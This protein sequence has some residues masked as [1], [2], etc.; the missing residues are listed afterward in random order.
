[1]KLSVKRVFVSL[2]LC[3]VTLSML[4]QEKTLQYYNT[5]ESEILPDAQTAFKKGDYERTL[6][7]CRWHYI[8][9]GDDSAYALR[10]K[11]E[12]CLQLSKEMNNLRS[13]GNIKEAKLK[14]SALLS[15]NPD[16]S[17]AKA[18]MSL[19]EPQPIVLD[20]VSVAPPDETIE[21]VTVD[22]PK[23]R[24]TETEEKTEPET[25]QPPIE[26]PL[27]VPIVSKPEVTPVMET[28]SH[29]PHTRFV[30]KAGASVLDLKQLSQTVAPEGIIGLYG[31]T[32]KFPC[33][34]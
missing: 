33:L 2:S 19:E 22:L 27:S 20:T 30:I 7:L 18:I 21:S 16:D 5:H 3:L 11:S 10:D 28:Q 34:M 17:A 14:A 1:M 9:F 29:E 31:D 23:E 26:D 6:E 8:I 24:I 15:I 4:A 13:E 12:R 32:C 25:V